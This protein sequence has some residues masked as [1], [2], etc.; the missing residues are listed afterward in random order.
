MSG[1]KE[2]PEH[3]AGGANVFADTAVPDAAEHLLKARIVSEIY[4][5]VKSRRLTQAKAGKLLGIG[6]ADVSKMLR[7]DFRHYSVERLLRFLT[8]FDRDVDIVI[9]KRP[10]S[11][12]GP[13]VVNIKA[14]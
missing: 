4:D 2:L 6:Q 5:I 12:P 3:T 11:R 9:R 10:R 14:A 8:V 1:K 7:G 13:G